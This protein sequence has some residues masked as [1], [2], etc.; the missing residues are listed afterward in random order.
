MINV[1]TAVIPDVKNH[2]REVTT[3]TDMKILYIVLQNINAHL[4]TVTNS[5]SRKKDF[6]NISNIFITS[7]NHNDLNVRIPDAT[8]PSNVNLISISM[9]STNTVTLL[10]TSAPTHNVIEHYNVKVDSTSTLN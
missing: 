1:I 9:L 3:V 6:Y 4:S 2:S 10:V 5:S 8:R 7:M